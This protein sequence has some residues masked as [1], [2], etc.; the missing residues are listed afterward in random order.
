M[1]VENRTSHLRRTWNEQKKKSR[2]R[3]LTGKASLL[4]SHVI[5]MATIRECTART[6]KESQ[7]LKVAA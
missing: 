4:A 6:H 7:D 5:N 1:G 3:Y 2:G